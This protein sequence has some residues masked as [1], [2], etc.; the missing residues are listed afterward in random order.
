[1]IGDQEQRPEDYDRQIAQ[2]IESIVPY[3][4]A[5]QA[6]LE[7]LKSFKREVLLDQQKFFKQVYEPVR[8]TFIEDVVLNPRKRTPK[9]EG[10]FKWMGDEK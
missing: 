1:M 7:Y 8:D 3:E 2:R 10:L 4:K 6:A 5:W 9:P